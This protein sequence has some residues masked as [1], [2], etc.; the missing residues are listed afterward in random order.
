VSRGRTYRTQAVVLR[1][2]DFG[3]ADRVLT[4]FTHADGKVKAVAKGVRRTTSRNGGHLELFA[5][6]DVLLA[7]GRELDVV[8]QAETI[9]S[10]RRLRE[11][12]LRTAYAYELA[13]L[14]DAL[15]QPGQAN[16]ALFAALLQALTALEEAEDPRLVLGHFVLAA[17]DATG[18]RPQ[19]GECV[20]CRQP[21]KPESNG[22]DRALGGALCPRCLPA[23]PGARPIAVNVLKL[24]RLLQ[25][26]ESIGSVAVKVPPEV[27]REAERTL[28]EYAEGVLEH[29]L[30]S[31]GFVARVREA[32]AAYQVR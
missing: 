26:S 7:R 1:R 13:E 24:L 27:A 14:V 21:L 29:Q 22:F 5:H 16:P 23:T 10:F 25:R 2:V 19:L 32:T 4:L 3:E 11:D 30:R 9:R 28:R 8:A 15:T 6:S 20:S 12:L 31:P 17:L 18:F